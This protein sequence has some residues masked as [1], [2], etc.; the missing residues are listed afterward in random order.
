MRR[1][2]NEGLH[3]VPSADIC[4]SQRPESAFGWVPSGRCWFP[5]VPSKGYGGHICNLQPGFV[6]VQVCAYM[7]REEEIAKKVGAEVFPMRRCGPGS[8]PSDI[9]LHVE[10]VITHAGSVPLAATVPAPLQPAVRLRTLHVHTSSCGDKGYRGCGCAAN[11][12][13]A[14]PGC[15]H[16]VP[17]ITLVANNPKRQGQETPNQ[18]DSQT[19]QEAAPE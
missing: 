3:S 12:A 2:Q 6:R 10:P 7:H 17:E 4:I 19:P 5:W 15:Q 16:A 9:P 13:R 1:I 8:C 18:G 14:L 11:T